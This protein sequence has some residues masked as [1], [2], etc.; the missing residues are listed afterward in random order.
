MFLDRRYKLSFESTMARTLSTKASPLWTPA[1][2]PRMYP[3][4]SL[5]KRWWKATKASASLRAAYKKGAAS[6]FGPWTYVPGSGPTLLSEPSV[7]KVK[8]RARF[9]A[10]GDDAEH[11]PAPMVMPP[12]V[13]VSW[14]CGRDCLLGGDLSPFSSLA[15]WSFHAMALSR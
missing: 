8:A 6:T 15:S 1:I 5:V 9:L 3:G 2:A 11:W 7:V 14:V 12:F 13:G 4:H 10:A